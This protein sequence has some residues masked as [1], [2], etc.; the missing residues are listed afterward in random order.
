MYGNLSKIFI[1]I[2]YD[3]IMIYYD[4]YNIN[5]IGKRNQKEVLKFKFEF[6][7]K[8]MKMMILKINI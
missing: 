8:I 1:K 3:I 6:N 7:N 2:E 4:S 5:Y